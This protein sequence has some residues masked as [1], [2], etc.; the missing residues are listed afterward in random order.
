MTFPTAKEL[1]KLA[2]AC[3]KAGIKVFECPDYK[4]TLSD[5]YVASRSAYKSRKAQAKG[6]IQ[7]D[8]VPSENGISGEELLY[9]SAG[10]PPTKEDELN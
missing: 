8:E 5:Y 9:Y 6:S 1:K 3:R 4:I 10:G 7:S 2:D